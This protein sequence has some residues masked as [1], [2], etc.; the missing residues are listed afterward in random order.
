[1]KLHKKIIL[2]FFAA[3][4]PF[5]AFTGCESL[6]SSRPI[7]PIKEYEKMLVGRLDAN[8]VGTDNCLS[9]CHYHDEYRRYFEAST[10]GA[11]LSSKSGL[12][13]VDCESCHGPGSLAVKG[14]T[15]EKVEADREAGTQTECDYETFIDIQEL[16]PKAQSLICNKCH[17]ANATF[18]LH[19]WNVGA[20]AIE[21]VTCTDCHNVHAGPDLIVSPRE[22]KDMCFAC[23]QAVMAEFT[24][25]SHHP[26]VE[27]KIFCTDCHDPHGA[28]GD[29]LLR[30]DT[31]KET[32]TKCHGEKE[33]PFMFEH[34]DT[35]ED[36][37]RC[38]R[39][40]GSVN[41]H[42]LVA[43][44]TFLCMQCHAGHDTSS[45]VSAEFKGAFYT[46]C[47]DC[48]SS[49][50]GTDLPSPSGKGRFIN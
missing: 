5:A 44:E 7:L 11:Q 50:H 18:N 21:D 41:S 24:L 37:S 27:K 39:S 35:M 13:M 1:M 47:S 48:H 26:V 22:T 10:M 6:K 31:V 38:H 15:R 16:P 30:A 23:H 12:P 19:D 36:C 9:A 20:H 17:T 25:R 32:C 8:Y 43:Q 4:L 45:A 46:R 42:L 2:T 49:I 33:G 40:H 28:I 34:A 29:D 14:L 3:T